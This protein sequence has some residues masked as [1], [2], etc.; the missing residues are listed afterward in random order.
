MEEENGVTVVFSQ[1]LHLPRRYRLDL[2]ARFMMNRADKLISRYGWK[3]DLIHGQS[4]YPA[5]LAAYLLSLRHRVPFIITLRDHLSHLEDMLDKGSPSFFN[6]VKQMFNQV[7]GILVHGPAILRDL[8]SY[9]ARK[10]SVP[11]LLAPNGVDVEGIENSLASFPPI[12]PHRWGRI[13]SV[14]NLYRTKGIHENLQ[15]LRILDE[16][17]FKEWHYTVVGHGPYLKELETLAKAKGLWERIRFVGRVAHKEAIRQIRDA[18][19]FCL[20]SWEES[21][22]NVYAEAA[23]CGRPAIGCQGFGAELTIRNGATGLLVPPKDVNALA[24]ALYFLLTHP[25]E[26]RKMGEEAQGHIR[27]FTWDRT[28]QIYKQ[29]IGRIPSKS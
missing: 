8:P 2:S 6:L 29:A 14:G 12:Q 25:Q 3:F 5:G 11:T 22:G 18:D 7:N 21:F 28:A 23:V 13:I 26:A 17:G 1:Y 24:E 9:L 27:Q 19:I 4:I 16:R 10:S 20:P 15:A